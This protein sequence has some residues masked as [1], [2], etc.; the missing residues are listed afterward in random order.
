[1]IRELEYFELECLEDGSFQE[2]DK[3]PRCVAS[4]LFEYIFNK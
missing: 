4:N 2:P 3:W 1:M